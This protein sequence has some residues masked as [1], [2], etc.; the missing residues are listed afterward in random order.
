[1]SNR[2]VRASIKIAILIAAFALAAAIVVSSALARRDGS[3]AVVSI[4]ASQLHVS[5]G[6]A[7]IDVPIVSTVPVTDV[8]VFCEVSDAGGSYPYSTI[9]ASLDGSG[10]FPFDWGPTTGKISVDCTVDYTDSTTGISDQTGPFDFTV[11]AV[12]H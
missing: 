1:M 4:D 7:T 2:L 12:G 5:P 6:T 8:L 3:P 11:H 10:T 9:L